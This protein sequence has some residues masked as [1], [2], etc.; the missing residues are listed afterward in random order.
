MSASS[1]S[2]RLRKPGPDLRE[3]S[4]SPSIWPLLAALAV[5]GT[6]LGSIFTPWAVVWGPVP[7]AVALIGS[8]W[9]KNTPEDEKSGRAWR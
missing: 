7:I 3:T 5:G 2:R 4:A 6:F 1:W 8:F 9:P